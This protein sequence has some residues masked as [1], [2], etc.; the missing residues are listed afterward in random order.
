MFKKIFEP[1]RIGQLELKNRLVFPAITANY[2]TEEGAMTEVGKAFYVERAKG[3]AGLIITG[4]FA[5]DPRGHVLPYQFTLYNKANHKGMKDLARLIQSHGSKAAFQLHHAGSRAAPKVSGTQPVTSSPVPHPIHHERPGFVSCK[6]RALTLGEVR[7]MVKRYAWAAKIGQDLGFDAVEVHCA[8]AHLIDQFL[9]PLL[10][11][12]QDGYGGD[13]EARTRFAQEVVAEVRQVVGPGY[14]IICKIDGSEYV[15]GGT[16]LEDAK[17]VARVLEEAGADA[18][19]VSV[20]QSHRVAPTPPSNFPQGCFV[21]LAAGIK[22]VVSIPVIAVGRIH[23]LEMAEEIL[24]RGKADLVAMGRS[25]LA[26]PHLPQKAMEGRLEEVKPCIACIQGCITRIL[27]ALPMLCSVNPEVGREG[28]F[29]IKKA[30]SRKRV[31]IAGGGPAGLETAR[32]AQSRGHQVTLF[33]K[34]D[35]LGGYLNVAALAPYKEEFKDLIEFYKHEMERLGVVVRLHTEVDAELIRDMGPDIVVVATGSVPFIPQIKGIEKDHVVTAVEALTGGK[36]TGS[37]IVILGGGRVGCETAE[38]LA[39]KGKS[40]TLIEEGDE[41]GNGVPPRT[42]MFLLPRLIKEGVKILK[43]TKVEEIEDSGVKVFQPG[44]VE[45]IEADT[46]VIAMGFLPRTALVD[47]LE[48]MIPELK[49]FFMIGDCAEP[50]T[51][52]E[53]VYDGWR[54]GRRI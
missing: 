10:N 34:S 43:K 41:V 12:R 23:H 31:L 21:P 1:V 25:L 32:V 39:L 37:H 28:T 26:D 3:G 35:R 18:F 20:G 27:S 36:G 45:K 5:I 52:E 4:S 16:T 8:H 24:Q 53:A 17:V 9:S 54:I 15:E 29:S 48:A 14:P 7:E 30:K 6:P 49:G 38:F 13:L 11:H 46:I 47:T 42:R 40:V 51:V 50:R 2:G 44:K 33:E 19:Q 22:E